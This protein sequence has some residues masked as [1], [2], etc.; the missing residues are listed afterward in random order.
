[1]P[2]N[3]ETETKPIIVYKLLA[4]D[5]NTQLLYDCANK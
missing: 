5:R 2:F 4:S 3:K 1:M